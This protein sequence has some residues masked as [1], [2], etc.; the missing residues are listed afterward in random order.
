ML[1]E[2]VVYPPEADLVQQGLA[3][4]GARVACAPRMKPHALGGQ[5]VREGWSTR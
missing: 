1:R 4:D 2:V 5:K 3:A